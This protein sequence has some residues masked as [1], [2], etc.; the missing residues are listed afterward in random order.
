[1][2]RLRVRWAESASLDLV[3]IIEF[4]MRER[5]EAA[6]KLG[7]TLFTEGFRLARNP[8]RGKVVPELLDRGIAD[9]RQLIISSYRL[10][11]AVRT[12]YVDIVAVLDGRRDIQSA[13][14]QRLQR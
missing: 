10:I 13:L 4:V 12:E 3:E 2:K 5:P 1:M 11:Y 6:R 14:F 7:R 8:H 9:Y